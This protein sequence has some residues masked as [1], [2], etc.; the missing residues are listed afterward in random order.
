[1]GSRCSRAAIT[2]P[3]AIAIGVRGAEVVEQPGLVDLARR[4]EAE[5]APGGAGQ[6]AAARRALQEALLQEVR[7]DHLLERVALLGQRCREGVDADGA[8]AVVVGDA[9]QIAAI[10]TV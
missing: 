7:L 4:L 2:P 9:A 3:S 6:Q 10:G 8:A 5:M 1:M